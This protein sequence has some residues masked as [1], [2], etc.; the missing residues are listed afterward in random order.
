VLIARGISVSCCHVLLFDTRELIIMPRRSKM[1]ELELGHI[2]LHKM[3]WYSPRNGHAHQQSQ[4][5]GL[6]R[7]DGRAI[8][9]RIEM[10]EL[11]SEQILGGQ[12]RA[13]TCA[14][15]GKD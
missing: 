14:L 9:E 7:M 11:K 3:F 1:G 8:T 5:R 2:H 13:W 6:G 15:G 12:A 4:I 10:G